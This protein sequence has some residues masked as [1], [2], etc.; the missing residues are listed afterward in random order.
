[1]G[2]RISLLSII[3]VIKV[4]KHPPPR[5]EDGYHDPSCANRGPEIICR[6]IGKGSDPKKHCLCVHAKL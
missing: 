4:H 3:G 1:M 5:C 6:V 2:F